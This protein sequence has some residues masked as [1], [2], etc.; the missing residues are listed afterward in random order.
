MRAKIIKIH[1]ERISFQLFAPLLKGFEHIE[2]EETTNIEFYSSFT[3]FITTLNVDSDG[4][5][6]INDWASALSRQ[7]CHLVAYL[8]LRLDL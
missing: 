2:G 7:G 6:S 3:I 1:L 5:V 4:F 8:I